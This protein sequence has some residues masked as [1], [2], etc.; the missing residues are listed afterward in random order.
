MIIQLFRPTSFL[1]PMRQIYLNLVKIIRMRRGFEIF[2]NRA[3]PFS[4]GGYLWKG[5]KSA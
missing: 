4:K 3:K 1:E 2:K 5:E